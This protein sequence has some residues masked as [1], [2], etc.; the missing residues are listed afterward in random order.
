MHN[1][2][3][4]DITCDRISC[5]DYEKILNEESNMFREFE[6]MEIGMYVD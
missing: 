1:S 2:D 4:Y 3:L 6:E 5:E